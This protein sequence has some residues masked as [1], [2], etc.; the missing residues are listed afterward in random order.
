MMTNIPELKAEMVVEISYKGTN[1]KEI[2]IVSSNKLEIKVKGG[3]LKIEWFD[4]TLDNASFNITKIYEN[5]EEGLKLIFDR[6]DFIDWSKVQVDTKIYVRNN[7]METLC[8]RHFAK[9]EDGKVYAWRNGTTSFS[10]SVCIEWEQAK[11]AE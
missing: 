1:E 7:D 10:G 11:L 3:Y 9:Y 4:E 6:K 2:G 5:T 8:L